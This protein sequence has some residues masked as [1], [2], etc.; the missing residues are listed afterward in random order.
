MDNKDLVFLCDSFYNL[1]GLPIRYY[2]SGELVR[3]LPFIIREADPI[4]E[5]LP[6]MLEDGQDINYYLSENLLFYGKVK[7]RRSDRQFLIGPCSNVPLTGKD[8]TERLHQSTEN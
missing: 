5:V 7:E 6:R 8:E 1:T 2:E 4:H 3:M